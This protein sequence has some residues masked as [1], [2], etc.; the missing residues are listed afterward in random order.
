MLTGVIDTFETEEGY[1]F[2]KPDDSRDKVFM[3][4]TALKQG[5]FKTLSPG[6][7]VKFLIMEGKKGPQAVMVE[8]ID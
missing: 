6:Q 4:Y 7:K 3:Y 5:D 1:G 8:L 2:I